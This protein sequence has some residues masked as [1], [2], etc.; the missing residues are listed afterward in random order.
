MYF[1]GFNDL[2]SDV[3]VASAFQ[4]RN[5]ASPFRCSSTSSPLSTQ[6]QVFW[7]ASRYVITQ[8]CGGSIHG[9][10]GLAAV[11]L[12]CL[13]VHAMVSG[14]VCVC[15]CVCVCMCVCVCAESTQY[16]SG[17]IAVDDMCGCAV[18]HAY[19]VRCSKARRH[20]VQLHLPSTYQ[21]ALSPASFAVASCTFV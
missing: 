2:L 4:M 7:L 21:L 15:V 14:Y 19:C 17:L 8:F 18:S 16:A 5:C 1:I 6:M 12:P 20:C 10:I 3:S 11:D 9:L 13:P